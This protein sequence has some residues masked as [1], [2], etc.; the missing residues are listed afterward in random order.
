RL[1]RTPSSQVGEREIERQRHERRGYSDDVPLALTQHF[2]QSRL[3]RPFAAVGI[4]HFHLVTR[5]LQHP[6][7]APDPE[8]RRQEGVFATMGIVGTDQEEGRGFRGGLTPPESVQEA[9]LF[10]FS[11]RVAHSNSL[12]GDR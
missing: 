10:L 3:H 1:G 8:G 6:R 2:F 7:K 9:T 5:R 11:L 12:G 4:K